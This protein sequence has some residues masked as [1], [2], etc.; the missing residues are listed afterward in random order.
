M[1]V[2]VDEDKV[3][4]LVE[5]RKKGQNLEPLASLVTVIV[6]QRRGTNLKLVESQVTSCGARSAKQ[7]IIILE[8]NGV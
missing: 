1:R 4:H 5:S 3:E 2:E 8:Q 6:V 7:E